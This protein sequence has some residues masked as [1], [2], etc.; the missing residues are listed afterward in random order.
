MA[1]TLKWFIP[2]PVTY[3]QSSGKNLKQ[4][5]QGNQVLN[6]NL[7]TPL[8]HTDILAIIKIQIL[9]VKF[10]LGLL[11]HHRT[12]VKIITTLDPGHKAS[13]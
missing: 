11:Y 5:L 4:Y 12:T 6:K 7:I 2:D 3:S 10:V 1:P 9:V 8:T 13:L